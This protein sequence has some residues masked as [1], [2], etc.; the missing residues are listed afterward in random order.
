M[1]AV[2]IR[3]QLR[4]LFSTSHTADN[5]FVRTGASAAHV[6]RRDITSRPWVQWACVYGDVVQLTILLI[7]DFPIAAWLASCSRRV[8]E[9]SSCSEDLFV[10]T[11]TEISEVF[12]F[13]HRRFA[14]ATLA[15]CFGDRRL[16]CSVFNISHT[17]PSFACQQ[18]IH[19]IITQT[20]P[21]I[22]RY[23]IPTLLQTDGRPAPR[24]Y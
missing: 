10:V 4:S 22:T 13:K 21:W 5:T 11:L 19:E 7:A 24:A 1:S 2:A 20:S 14:R 3:G 16:P 18:P 12:V 9:C 15:L 17:N 23:S 6:H 8:L